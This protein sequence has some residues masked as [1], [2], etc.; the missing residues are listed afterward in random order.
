M[1]SGK[2][3][4]PLRPDSVCHA[5]GLRTGTSAGCCFFSAIEVAHP[6]M[7]YILAVY[8]LKVFRRIAG[9]PDSCALGLKRRVEPILSKCGRE[10]HTKGAAKKG[11]RHNSALCSAKCFGEIPLLI[12]PT[13]TLTA[14]SAIVQLLIVFPLQVAAKILLTISISNLSTP[15]LP[16]S[17]M[18]SSEF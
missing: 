12:I 1:F 7:P 11:H 10:I 4:F 8:A 5:G 16:H 6:P 9:I 2:S 18:F 17:S 13:L 3:L 15:V 14:N